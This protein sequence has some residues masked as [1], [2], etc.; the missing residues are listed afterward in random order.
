MIRR[1][2]LFLYIGLI[3][4]IVFTTFSFAVENTDEVLKDVKGTAY[5]QA[6]QTLLEEGAISG[7]QEGVFKPDAYITR[8]EA[9]VMI[10]K[11][12]YSSKEPLQSV[13]NSSFSDMNGYGWASPYVNYAAQNGVVSGYGKG[14]FAPDKNITYNELV[15]ML[16]SAK[17]NTAADLEGVWPDNY[18]EKAKEMGLFASISNEVEGNM[19]AT[20]GNAAIMI[21]N[22]LI[23]R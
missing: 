23:E 7:Y 13:K 2:L 8:A 22:G 4:M 15:A 5:E 20:R 21:C 6:V 17:G 10:V 9:C 14:V 12:I 3:I 18:Y 11:I 16:V 1:K 19:E